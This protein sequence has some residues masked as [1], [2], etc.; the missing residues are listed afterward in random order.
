MEDQQATAT[1]AVKAIE[2]ATQ[3]SARSDSLLPWPFT[4]GLADRLLW[5]SAYTVGCGVAGMPS[6]HL[7]HQEV[8]WNGSQQREIAPYNQT[9]QVVTEGYAGYIQE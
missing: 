2:L 1:A 5:V 3:G 8:P 7:V 9:V 4:G 6:G